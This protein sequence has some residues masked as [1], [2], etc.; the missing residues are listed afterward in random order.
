MYGRSDIKTVPS[1]FVAIRGRGSPPAA[2]AIPYPNPLPRFSSCCNR[3]H[4]DTVPHLHERGPEVRNSF[5]S[6]PLSWL[7]AIPDNEC[8]PLRFQLRSILPFPFLSFLSFVPSYLHIS[9]TKHQNWG[10]QPSLHYHKNTPSPTQPQT[11]KH[12][13]QGHGAEPS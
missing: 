10:S 11:N 1:S 5:V 3:S 12:T 7:V 8:A 9:P 13:L 2:P 4:S 6:V